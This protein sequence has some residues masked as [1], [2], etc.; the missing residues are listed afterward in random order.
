MRFGERARVVPG[1]ERWLALPLV[2]D[3]QPPAASPVVF[4]GERL[5][6]G[7][8]EG[9]PPLMSFTAVPLARAAAPS[10]RCRLNWSL[11]CRLPQRQ[12]ATVL[13]DHE[14]D[15]ES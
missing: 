15:A 5:W 9:S 12:S 4:E 6:A 8:R 7:A 14:L 10:A 2:K 13:P 3:G 11:P 1:E